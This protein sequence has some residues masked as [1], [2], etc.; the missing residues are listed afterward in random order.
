MYK[1]RQGLQIIVLRPDHFNW[2]AWSRT[3][4][5]RCQG[6]WNVSPGAPERNEG[7]LVFVNYFSRV[8]SFVWLTAHH[9]S[10]DMGKDSGWS[11]EKKKKEMTERKIC[12]LNYPM[13]LQSQHLTTLLWGAVCVLLESNLYTSGKRRITV[14]GWRTENRGWVPLLVF[15][16]I[17]N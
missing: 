14:S 8:C 15:V 10:K 13:C 12:L 5:L 6:G 3:W 11:S 1:N 17:F 16:P 9:Q 7:C 4:N 2:L